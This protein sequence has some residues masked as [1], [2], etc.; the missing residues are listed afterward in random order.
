LAAI[1]VKLAKP[2]ANAETDATIAEAVGIK[3]DTAQTTVATTRSIMA[4][5]K[6]CLNQ[7]STV[8]TS[9][10]TTIPNL[11]AVPAKDATTDTN[12]RDVI[13]KKDDTAQTTVGTTRSLMA[14]LKGVVTAVITT[15]PGLHAVPTAD[16]ETNTNMRD[17]IGNKT[18]AA[19]TTVGTTKSLMAYLKGA[20]NQLADV[21]SYIGT[22]TRAFKTQ[23]GTRWDSS[24]DLGTD[25]A[26]IRTVTDAVKTLTTSSGTLT[27]DGTE[28]DVYKN[29]AP[30]QAYIARHVKIDFTNHTTAE[31]VIVKTYYRIKNGGNY[32][33]QDS[34]SWTLAVPDYSL[35]NVELEPNKYGVKV[36]IEKTA[37]TNRDYDW[38]VIF[39]E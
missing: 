23:W 2:A 37:G 22:F 9:T 1:I 24:G 13:G 30:A 28:Q 3:A 27:T 32:I 17:V 29:D 20:L 21:K 16:V 18:D 10:G 14:Y 15:I 4:Y 34:V 26:A 33:L 6:G 7:L 35:I 11:H 25:V 5:V 8:I 31:S 39:E 19:V 38:E 12:M 36:T